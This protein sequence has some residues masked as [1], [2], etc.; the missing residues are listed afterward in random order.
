[1]K[2]NYAFL[3]LSLILV[4]ALLGCPEIP[5]G[6]QPPGP[7]PSPGS[8]DYYESQYFRI[9]TP[10]GWTV[11]ENIQENEIV[12]FLNIADSTIIAI[13]VFPAPTAFHPSFDSFSQASQESVTAEGLFTVTETRNSKLAG[14]TALELLLET[15]QTPKTKSRSFLTIRNN[16]IY[17]V[18]YAAFESN[19]DLYMPIFEETAGSMEIPTA[20][21]D[22]THAVFKI[23]YP[24]GWTVEEWPAASVTDFYDYFGQAGFQIF[25]EEVEANTNLDSYAANAIG[26]LSLGENTE[27]QEPTDYNI[28]GQPAKKVVYIVSDPE[29]EEFKGN[30]IYV[31]SN[32]KAYIITYATYTSNYAFYETIFSQMLGSMQLIAGEIPTPEGDCY[33]QYQRTSDICDSLSSSDLRDNCYEDYAELNQNPFFCDQIT[34]E[35]KKQNCYTNVGN[36]ANLPPCENPID[37]GQYQEF[38][39]QCSSEPEGSQRDSC[40]VDLAKTKNL[41]ALCSFLKVI[42]KD[43]CLLGVATGNNDANTC[44]QIFQ[45]GQRNSCLYTIGMAKNDLEACKAIE[46]ADTSAIEKRDSC[47]NNAAVATSNATACSF[48]SASIKDGTYIRDDCYW[49]VFQKTSNMQLC[50]KLIDTERK[51]E[52]LNSTVVTNEDIDDCKALPTDQNIDACLKN[53]AITQE[54]YLICAEIT[55]SNSRGSCYNELT[56]FFDSNSNDTLCKLIVRAEDKSN[57]YKKLADATLNEEYCNKLSVTKDR[58]ECISSLGI[59]KSDPS[60]CEKILKTQTVPWDDCFEAIALATDD[61]DLCTR[62]QSVVRMFSC[63]GDLAVEL[64]SLGICDVFPDRYVLSYSSYALDHLCYKYYSIETDDNLIC[65]RIPAGDVHDACVDQNVSFR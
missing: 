5:I 23:K 54:N 50:E 17:T 26:L 2:Y 44:K 22:Y 55:D 45:R 15:S 41:T 56:S 62:I 30:E 63:V 20:L 48:M 52:C 24:Q 29:D 13:S 19:Y 11:Q 27:V 10:A 53:I 42:S 8:G 16:N 12:R 34:E 33:S 36:P 39:D 4:L 40:L 18:E 21:S 60:V 46:E 32:N 25:V 1:M 58:S 64:K 59:E 28:A 61:A 43:D 3:A 51:T 14:N 57:C 6:P 47:L 9:K 37:P 65:D 49:D 38:I 7:G 31:I 35:T